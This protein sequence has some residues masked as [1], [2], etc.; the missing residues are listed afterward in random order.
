MLIVQLQS[1]LHLPRLDAIGGSS[2]GILVDNQVM[3]ASL[4]R[5]V[6][7][8]QFDALIAALFKGYT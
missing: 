4:F 3:V 7:K 2:A 5:A 6:P 1:E 8:D